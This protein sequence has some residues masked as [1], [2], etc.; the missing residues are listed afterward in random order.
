ML[1][2]V[3][4]TS[5]QAVRSGSLCK[6]TAFVIQCFMLFVHVS[7]VKI[8]YD[9]LCMFT[10]PIAHQRKCAAPQTKSFMVVWSIPFILVLL[11]YMLLSFDVL[12]IQY[13]KT[14]WLSGKHVFAIL[15]IPVCLAM[16]FNI[17]CFIRSI[18]KMRKLEQNSQMLRAQKQEN[19][20][21]P[22]YLKIS[23]VFGLGWAS[24]FLAVFFPVFSYL[25]VILTGISGCVHFLCVCV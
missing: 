15:Y 7:M 11:C 2:L 17:V 23:T 16:A 1:D 3:W 13:T 24:A 12:D 18:S 14:C 9:T 21:I 25:F 19:K 6:T 20:L 10:D 4:L 5:P 8:A 22:V